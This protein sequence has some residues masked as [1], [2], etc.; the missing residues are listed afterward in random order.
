KEANLSEIVRELNKNK[1]IEF[2]TKVEQE[3]LKRMLQNTSPAQLQVISEEKKKELDQLKALREQLRKQ[4][5]AIMEGINSLYLQIQNEQANLRFFFLEAEKKVQEKKERE[6]IR[7]IK[8][9][10]IFLLYA[11][12]LKFFLLFF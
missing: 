4:E 6:Y 5:E 9:I 3:E 1:E 10:L 7:N 11:Y 8:S 2:K 12:F